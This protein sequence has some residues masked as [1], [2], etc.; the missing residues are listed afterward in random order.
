MKKVYW[1]LF[2]V[3][4]SIKLMFRFNLG[5]IVIYQGEEYYLT[6]GVRNPYWNLSKVKGEEYLKDIHKNNFTKKKSIENYLSSFQMAYRFYMTSWFNIWVSKGIEPWMRGCN[7][8]G[9]RN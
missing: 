8:W 9:D 6:Q 4:L 3:M 1:R 5:D 7:I 2:I